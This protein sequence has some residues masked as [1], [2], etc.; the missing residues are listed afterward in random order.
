M[1]PASRPTHQI[2]ALT[3]RPNPPGIHR[4]IKTVLT[5]DLPLAQ[6]AITPGYSGP[7]E[8]VGL[9]DTGASATAINIRV[10]AQ[11]G[12]RPVGQVLVQTANKTVPADTYLVNLVLLP[13]QVHFPN[14]LVSGSDLGPVDVLIGMDIITSGDFSI[15]NKNGRTVMSFRKPSMDTHDYVPA[16]NAHNMIFARS[17]NLNSSKSGKI[18]KSR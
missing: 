13:S 7:Q 4:E 18:K 3:A 1:T 16:A 11:L 9:W 2:Q 15:T 17:Q 5:L 10:A 12:L 14:I 8:F 6:Q